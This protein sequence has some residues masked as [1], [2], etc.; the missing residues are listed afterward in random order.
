MTVQ[1]IPT[2]TEPFYTQETSL[3]GSAY[4]LEFRYS[5]REGTWYFSLGLPDGTELASGVKV[6]CNRPLLKRWADVRLPPGDILAVPNDGDD[7]PPGLEELGEGRRV[8]L[9]YL[10]SDG[11]L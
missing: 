4:S 10:P 5:Q 7:S 8:T 3:E 1:I 2:D 9:L 6:M 11:V